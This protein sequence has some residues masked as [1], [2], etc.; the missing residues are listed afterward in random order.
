MNVE[1]LDVIGYF[2]LKMAPILTMRKIV[3]T[4][5][6]SNAFI[7]N[8]VH[9]PYYENRW[10]LHPIA[11]IT[12]EPTG[13]A[14]FVYSCMKTRLL[15]QYVGKWPISLVYLSKPLISL[16]AATLYYFVYFDISRVSAANEWDIELTT[17]REIPY[18]HAPM[19]YSLCNARLIIARKARNIGMKYC[20]YQIPRQI[21]HLVAICTETCLHYQINMCLSFCRVNARIAFYKK[22]AE[23]YQAY[24][25]AKADLHNA[26]YCSWAAAPGASCDGVTSCSGDF[27]SNLT[28]FECDLDP[29]FPQRY[30]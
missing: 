25:C 27:L 14:S 20:H 6:T 2:D 26:E 11:V 28:R 5:I 16:I 1:T 23:I 9:I 17:P 30:D 15:G 22:K 13:K 18:L 21:G 10:S 29:V 7:V 3:N 8:E 12:V 19:Y 4:R 24:Q